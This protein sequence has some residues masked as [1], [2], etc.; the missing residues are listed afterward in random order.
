MNI[1]KKAAVEFCL[2]KYVSNRMVDIWLTIFLT[3]GLAIIIFPIL[4]W[5]VYRYTK[6]KKQVKNL[7]NQLKD[8]PD[9]LDKI[10]AVSTYNSVI[11]QINGISMQIPQLYL[12]FSKYSKKDLIKLLNA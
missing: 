5:L 8:T 11:V 12:W 3:L 10:H 4:I 7:R 1:H 2:D 6:T 9:M